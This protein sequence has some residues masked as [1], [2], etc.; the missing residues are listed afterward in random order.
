MPIYNRIYNEEDWSKVNKENKN[1]MEDFL[2]EYKQQ[3]KKPSTLEQYKYDLQIIMI[4][5]LKFC[6]NQS[7][8]S[9]NKKHFRN[10]SLWLTEELKQ[11]SARSNRIMSCTRSLL[12][13][14][15]DDDDYEY[16]VNYAK[17]VKGLP[18]EQVRDI[19]FLA[20]DDILKLKDY[21]VENKEYQKATLVMLLYDSAGRKNEVAQVQ[22]HSFFDESKNSTNR[23]IG[24]RGK[25][26]PL[27]YFN[28]TKECAK[29]WLEQRGEDDIDG[30]FVIGNG[31]KKHAAT[32]E[33]IYYWIIG[34]RDELEN[35]CGKEIQFSPH[36][37]RHSSL[38][39][40][41]TGEH[42][43]C[44]DLKMD[45]GFPVEKLRLIANHSDLSTTQSYLKDKSEEE[46][47]DMFGIKMS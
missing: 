20:D 1:I 34:L 30:L 29:L 2:I 45:G 11:S 42:Y 22:K 3:K 40:Y 23:V 24:K 43:V 8:L 13:F 47:E 35:L 37:F 6:D 36:S 17:K 41:S 5:I 33:N 28:G 44:R 32:S 21:L 38:E 46:L 25:V 4:Y 31:D 14:C 19:H 18:K 27:L 39:N 15:E 10:L 16:D 26:F 9:L 7:I 12:T